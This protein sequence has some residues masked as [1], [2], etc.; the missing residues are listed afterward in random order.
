MSSK[1]ASFPASILVNRGAGTEGLNIAIVVRDLMQAWTHS[2]NAAR[3]VE[4]NLGGK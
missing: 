1:S 4:G 2:H 3:I